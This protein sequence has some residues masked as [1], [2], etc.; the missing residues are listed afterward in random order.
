MFA[1]A[2]LY[3]RFQEIHQGER[4]MA[5][6]GSEE[7]ILWFW[8][9]LL[10][11]VPP[12]LRLRENMMVPMW[13]ALLVFGFYTQSYWMPDFY[14]LSDWPRIIFTLL[15]ILGFYFVCGFIVHY[16]WFSGKS[17]RLKAY[18]AFMPLFKAWIFGKYYVVSDDFVAEIRRFK[19]F[20]VAWS[21][22]ATVEKD[23]DSLII[24]DTIKREPEILSAVTIGPEA[25]DFK[26]VTEK[27][28]EYGKI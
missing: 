20:D 3:A 6:F 5:E 21:D 22:I 23:G 1:G 9:V 18:G 13:G 26:K 12:V 24:R 10:I 4:E 28:K 15:L 27:L 25:P 7:N 11:T 8:A 19:L 16:L 17:A 2:L 14:A